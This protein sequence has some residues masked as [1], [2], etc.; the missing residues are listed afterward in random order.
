MYAAVTA[1][2]QLPLLVPVQLRIPLYLK[3]ASASF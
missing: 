2:V 3:H 1:H